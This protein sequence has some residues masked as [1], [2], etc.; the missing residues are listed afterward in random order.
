MPN[1][2]VQLC[3]EDDIPRFVEIISEAFAHDHEYV[4]AVFYKHETPE[5]RRNAAD[6][7]L[8]IYRHDPNGYFLKV[9]DKDTGKMVGA[10]KWN[11][12]NAGS[13]PP[14]PQLSG[15]Y[16]PNAEE[17][18]FAKA[19]FTSFFTPRQKIIEENNGCLVGMLHVHRRSRAGSTFHFLING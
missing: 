16:W 1:L 18:E 14:V 5:G 4:E 15:P 12:Y 8:M 10:A 9:I 17:E 11:I 19:I 6:L 2:E 3:N 13:I 7:M